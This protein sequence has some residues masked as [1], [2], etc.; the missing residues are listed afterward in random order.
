MV[1]VA[2]VMTVIVIVIVPLGGA[3]YRRQER[4]DQ[5]VAWPLEEALGEFQEDHHKGVRSRPQALQR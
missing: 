2:G 5:L 3:G 4:R 1:V